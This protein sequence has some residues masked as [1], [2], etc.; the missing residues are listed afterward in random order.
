MSSEVW[1]AAARSCP[2]VE[3]P[4]RRSSAAGALGGADVRCRGSRSRRSRHR[5]YTVGAAFHLNRVNGPLPTHPS[6]RATR[7]HV[8]LLPARRGFN[9]VSHSRTRC[10]SCSRVLAFAR[11]LYEEWPFD[12]I[13]AH[14]IYPNGVVASQIG[15]E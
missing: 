3:L 1:P 4:D 11:K 5:T 7:M 8:D 13:H 9:R 14:F 10:A 15:R 2:F 12:L 6:T